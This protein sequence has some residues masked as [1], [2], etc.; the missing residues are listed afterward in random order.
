M[1]STLTGASATPLGL[2]NAG[3]QGLDAQVQGV[4]NAALFNGVY[5]ADRNFNGVL[6]RGP[7]SRAVRLRAVLLARFNYYDLRVPAPIR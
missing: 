1:T 7:L 4:G 2:G 3:N 6:D 5:G